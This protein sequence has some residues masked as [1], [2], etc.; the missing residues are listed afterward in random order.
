MHGMSEWVC[1]RMFECVRGVCI[2]VTL[3]PLG[4][5][6]G[7]LRALGCAWLTSSCRPTPS[8]VDLTPDPP[9]RAACPLV[10][11]QGLGL[12][13]R[14]SRPGC[15]NPSTPSLQLCCGT[16]PQRPHLPSQVTPQ[17]P[18][19]SSVSPHPVAQLPHPGHC[20][21]SLSVYSDTRS[22]LIHLFLACQTLF[23]VR[24]IKGCDPCPPEF[25][26]PNA[27]KDRWSQS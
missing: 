26:G 17:A 24:Q 23:G 16:S 27:L 14:R 19:N 11:T 7:L 6:V 20:I 4:P 10:A 2:S 21:C 1:E 5:V 8:L 18:R 3:L 9:G 12:K 15:P 22:L 13:V 25:I